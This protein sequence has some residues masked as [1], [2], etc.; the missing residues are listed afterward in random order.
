[1]QQYKLRIEDMAEEERPSNRLMSNGISSLSNAELLSII[2]KSGSVAKN[3][4]NLSKRVLSQFDLKQVPY[5]S[6]GCNGSFMSE[7]LV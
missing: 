5:L 6:T 4:I 7:T 3:A 2:I 1:M